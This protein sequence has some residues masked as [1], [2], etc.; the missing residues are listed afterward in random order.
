MLFHVQPLFLQAST[1]AI[2]KKSNLEEQLHLGS[3]KLPFQEL[4]SLL[5]L[6]DQGT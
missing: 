5:P 4:L 1:E 6:A 2:K 3:E